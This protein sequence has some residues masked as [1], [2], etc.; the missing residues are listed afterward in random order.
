MIDINLR[1]KTKQ[2]NIPIS[3]PKGQTPLTVNTMGSHRISGHY[4]PYVNSKID[5][6]VNH[7][8]NSHWRFII[9]IKATQL[10]K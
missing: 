5:P 9:N 10:L 3:T 8:L 1:S 2:L 6:K 4:R 7:L